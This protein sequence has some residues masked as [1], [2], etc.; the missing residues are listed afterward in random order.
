MTHGDRRPLPEGWQWLKLNQI[1]TVN[2]HR[3][4]PLDRDGSKPTTFVPMSAVDDRTGTILRPELRPFAQVR[5]GYTYFEEDDVLFAKITPCM[6]N[7]KHAIARGLSDGIGFG[8]TE[9]HVIRPGGR[10]IP[11]WIHFFCR[12]PTFLRLAEDQLTGTVG[13]QRLPEE[14][15]S[16]TE[17]PL[18]PLEDQRRIASLLAGRLT[19]VSRARAAIEDQLNDAKALPAACLRRAFESLEAEGCATLRIGD[20]CHRR[21]EMIHPNDGTTGKLR[22]VG[23]EHIESNS[24]RRIGETELDA[25]S[26]DGRKPRFCRGDVLYGYLRPYLN[27]VWVAEFDGVSSVDQYAFSADASQVLPQYLAYYMRSPT[28]LS[29]APVGVTPGYLPRIRSDEVESVSLP[30]PPIDQQHRISDQLECELGLAQKI[31][32]CLEEQ[33]DLVGTLPATLIRSAFNGEF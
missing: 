15:L 11:E 8:S 18:P 16:S 9:F 31:R 21:Q 2:P 6:Q 26:L 1:C 33:L 17:I 29:R 28:Y 19:A 24:G 7:G 25:E 23:L 12:Q 30:V 27:K 13:Q 22:F 10:V 32:A 20:V 4:T 14:F 3:R 5:K